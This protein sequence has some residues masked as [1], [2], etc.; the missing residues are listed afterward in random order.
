MLRQW[1]SHAARKLKL[2]GQ[3]IPLRN[4]H[5]T[6]SLLQRDQ[7]QKSKYIERLHLDSEPIDSQANDSTYESYQRFQ[8]M[9]MG[10]MIIIGSIG[11]YELY[12]NWDYLKRKV[13]GDT[14]DMSKFEEVYAQIQAKQERKKN[15]LDALN[16]TVTN[17]NT[18]DV[19]G[20]YICGDNSTQMV[21]SDPKVKFQSVLKRL[22]IFDNMLV[23]DVALGEA[24]GALINE[25]GHLYQWGAGFGGN[26]SKPTL[27]GK[28]LVKVRISNGLVYALTK[29]GEVLFLPE[30]AN[31]QQQYREKDKGWL[32]SGTR[33]YGKLV[34]SRP[35]KDIATGKEH[36]VL[37]DNKGLVYTAATGLEPL[38][39][40]YGQ[41]G[42]PEYSQF[43]EPP[44]PNE[45]HE[46]TLLNRVRENNIL[47]QREIKKIAAGDYFTVCLDSLGN[48]W[49]FGK[50]TYGSLGKEVNYKTEIVPYPCKVELVSKRFKRSDLP[51]C[52]D[53]AAGGDT[54]FASFV[55]S[56][57]Y[58]LFE[59]SLKNS[60]DLDLSMLSEQQK[61]SLV[62]FAWGHGLKGEL[63]N[64]RFVHG[65]AEPTKIQKLNDIREYDETKGKLE[66]LGLRQWSIGSNHAVAT[67]SNGDVYDWGDN[68]FGQLGNGKRI[69]SGV[70][71]PVPALLE[72]GMPVVK[73]ENNRLQLKTTK[74]YEQ[75]AVAGP[76][77]T[78]IYYK[79]K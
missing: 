38:K 53:I 44:V 47:T 73:S 78:A 52:I 70:P 24:S 4:L 58:Q 50:N 29:R 56:D 10:A 74:K 17:P 55:S 69:R 8:A 77:T 35:I 62:H 3:I 54:A 14:Y 40:S 26:S 28:D 51:Q 72:P 65:Q 76:S 11:G 49:A 9:F 19:P 57:I 41:F 12:R 61:E 5:L 22:D 13:V 68:E 33:N 21:S 59:H 20:L 67:L 45:L 63:G 23:R 79:C 66:V 7:D 32:F 75:V 15:K 16:A 43:D 1:S 37:L 48:I 27:K 71:T 31:E 60:K 25:K 36:L 39:K 42:L 30:S 18:S 46:V 6:G 64:G 34:T 2:H